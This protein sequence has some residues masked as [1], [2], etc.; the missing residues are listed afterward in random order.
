MVPGGQDGCEFADAHAPQ[1]DT[2][3]HGASPGRHAPPRVARLIPEA[4]AREEIDRLLTAAGWHVCD[5]NAANIH[6]ARGV[7]IRKCPP[8]PGHGEADYLRYLD[9][10]A[11]GVIVAK[12]RGATLSRMEARFTNGL[13]PAL[14]SRNVFAFHRP[15]HLAELLALRVSTVEDAPAKPYTEGL[16]TFL[17]RLQ[18][19]PPFVRGWGDF[20]RG[21]WL[22]GRLASG[23]PLQL[24]HRWQP[25][26]PLGEA[27]L[28]MDGTSADMNAHRAIR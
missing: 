13:D 10:K 15:E 24:Y 12:K 5:F 19:M 28:A 4:R 3:G 11:A 27:G 2:T 7:A 14:R 21:F 23:K 18:A 22:A 16:R 17:E 20:A 8:N 9:G 26:R 1:K 6:A 25:T